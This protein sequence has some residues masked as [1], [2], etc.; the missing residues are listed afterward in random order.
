V[1]GP[2]ADVATVRQAIDQLEAA[3]LVAA[4]EQ[5]LVVPT[6]SGQELFER[7]TTATVRAGD[8]LFDGIAGQDLAVT[9]RV[10]DQITQRAQAV[11]QALAPLR[12]A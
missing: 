5:D 4:A 8:E 6:E 11:R 10:L 1:A 9:K 7:V 12:P 2:A 3:G